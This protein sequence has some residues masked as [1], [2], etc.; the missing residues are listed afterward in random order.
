[1]QIVSDPAAATVQP[2]SAGRYRVLLNQ[3]SSTST[4]VLS[5]SRWTVGRSDDCDLRLADPTIAPLQVVFEAA[6]DTLAFHDLTSTGRVLLDGR[7]C[8]EGHLPAGSTL[9]IGTTRLT[10]EPLGHTSRMSPARSMRQRSWM[11]ARK[12]ATTVAPLDASGLGALQRLLQ[13]PAAGN[14]EQVAR[15]A[16]EATMEALGGDL[17]LLARMDEKRMTVLASVSRRADAAELRLPLRTLRK[18]RTASAAWMTNGR[19]GRRAQLVV[20]VGD[21]GGVL[22]L[23]MADPGAPPPAPSP[24]LA[25]L[26]GEIAWLHVQLAT[27]REQQRLPPHRSP[28]VTAR[29]LDD[30]R[31]QLRRAAHQRLPVLLIGERGTEKEDLARYLHA[32]S[33]HAAE[34][35]VTMDAQMTPAGQQEVELLGKQRGVAGAVQRAGAGTLFLEQPEALTPSVQQRL[36][37]L[38]RRN[39]LTCRLVSS[40]LSPPA[41][42]ARRGQLHPELASRLSS[43]QLAVPPLRDNPAEILPLAECVLADLAGDRAPRHTLAEAT[44]HCLLQYSWPGNVDELRSVLT[45]AVAQSN[46][47]VIGPRL[48]PIEVRC[49]P[50][51]TDEDRQTLVAVEARHILQVLELF[52]CNKRA[53]ARALGIATSTLYEKL[54]RIAPDKA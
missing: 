42:T 17:G 31:A 28:L 38:L 22:V 14:A 37:K 2:P 3:G 46:S 4:Q 48:L 7:R 5:G 52:D 10:A 1:M 41:D 53:A 39:A 36:L 49:P 25:R 47:P 27:H 12:P 40:M 20:P 44:S 43:I 29:R 16:V 6:G 35:F 51:A 18:T 30:L 8:G 9:L 21:G 13:I 24:V 45:A 19:A 23:A 26:A 50:A 54:K 32:N 11:P 15:A 33:D 34:P